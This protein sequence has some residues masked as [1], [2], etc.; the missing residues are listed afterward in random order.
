MEGSQ[1][2]KKKKNKPNMKINSFIWQESLEDLME[3]CSHLKLKIMYQFK[4][5]LMQIKTM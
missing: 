2:E 5:F 1:R 3:L 4:I